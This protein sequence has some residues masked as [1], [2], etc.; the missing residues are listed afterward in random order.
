M[1]VTVCLVLGLALRTFAAPQVVIV[2]DQYGDFSNG[3]MPTYIEPSSASK[4]W[5]Q[6][7]TCGDC[8]ATNISSKNGF[9]M[10]G[11][12]H[13]ATGGGS[14]GTYGIDFT[15]TGKSDRSSTVASGAD[16]GSRKV[17]R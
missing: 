13:D 8:A 5:N 2:D 16:D 10:N 1:L 14:I 3:A 6:G 15:F 7:A 12:W 17:I 4:V 11:T 9:L